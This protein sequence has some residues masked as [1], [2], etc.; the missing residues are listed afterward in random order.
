[1][2]R[3]LPIATAVL[4]ALAG[5]SENSLNAA[6]AR[7]QPAVPVETDVNGDLLTLV[8]TP[9]RQTTD[10]GEVRAVQA[11]L[12]DPDFDELAEVELLRPFLT[13]GVVVGSDIT[14][15]NDRADLPFAATSVP[16]RLSFRSPLVASS[17]RTSSDL[18]GVF[19]V[20]L[21][22]EE[23]RV[24]IA[25]EDP[26][27]PLTTITLDTFDLPEIVEIELDQGVPAWGRVLENG[28]PIADAEVVAVSTSGIASAVAHTDEDGWYEV[29]VSPDTYTIRTSGRGD[30]FD[31]TLS[32]SV[33]IAELGVRQD[34]DYTP[35]DLN[36]LQARAVDASGDGLPLTPWRLRATSL[37]GYGSEARV[38]IT[39]VA[40]TQGNIVTQ[41]VPGTYTLELLAQVG[42]A[43]S[44]RRVTDIQI[45]STTTL[46]DVELRPLVSRSGFAVDPSGNGVPDATVR[47]TEIGFSNRSWSGFTDP[48]G[49]YEIQAGDG[50]LT[51][52]VSPPGHRDDLALTRVETDPDVPETVT[53]FEQGRVLNGRVSFE[54]DPENLALVELRDATGRVWA[55]GLT[56]S[57]GEF[58]VRVQFPQ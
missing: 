2:T 24:T 43:R 36:T 13:G 45:D 5:C 33:T 42:D 41:A 40:D 39:G 46:G 20:S 12:P 26:Q 51:C 48:F 21:V 35:R 9:G 3:L 57:D 10:D 38:E 52:F 27:I 32:R 23:Y 31:P 49:A 8:V 58:E 11:S 25:P 34:F 16:A 53:V 1:M 18:D 30:G 17:V 56:N 37:E 6:E 28:E 50:P 19:D 4:V 22:P 14:P 29:R 54:G 15:E 7:D 47:C 55:T 44:S